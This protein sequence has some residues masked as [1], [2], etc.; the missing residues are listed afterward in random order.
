MKKTKKKNKVE[1]GIFSNSDGC[2]VSFDLG[3]MLFRKAAG[4]LKDGRAQLLFLCG[5]LSSIT[6]P[7]SM[8]ILGLD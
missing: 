4:M 6:K 7:M 2:C 3:F 5:P 8:K 1:A